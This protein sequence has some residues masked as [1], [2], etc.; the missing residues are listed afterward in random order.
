MPRYQFTSTTRHL[1]AGVGPFAVAPAGHAS[2]EIG[3]EV[4]QLSRKGFQR[5][6]PM[7]H[8][9]HHVTLMGDA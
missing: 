3:E 4:V 5:T 8:P 6:Q 7:A 9:V 2:I 1:V